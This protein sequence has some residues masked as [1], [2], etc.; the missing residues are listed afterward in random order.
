MGAG[1]VPGSSWAAILSRTRSS[2]RLSQF[3]VYTHSE[4]IAIEGFDYVTSHDK[5]N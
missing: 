4:I 3:A 5:L 2:L 1:K